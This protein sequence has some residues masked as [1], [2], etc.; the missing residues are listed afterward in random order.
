[1]RVSCLVRVDE[2][3]AA[4][5]FASVDE[6]RVAICGVRVEVSRDHAKL[7]GT[8][9][10]RLAVIRCKDHSP[11]ETD[12]AFTVPTRLIDRLV[13]SIGERDPDSDCWDEPRRDGAVC[14]AHDDER[15][16]VTLT[17]DGLFSI[18]CPSVQQH[19]FPK[20]RNVIPQGEPQPVPEFSINP[21]LLDGFQKARHRLTGNHI[22][23][24]R[25]R[26]FAGKTDGEPGPVEVRFAGVE[27]F[28]GL[29]MLMRCTDPPPPELPTWLDLEPKKEESVAA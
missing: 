11:S 16:E 28:Y 5:I 21:Y 4:R 29:L 23:G 25:L 10:R 27:K 12:G 19:P 13:V 1:M 6:S 9:S 15:N 24:V 7:I 3:E 18:S 17:V 8:D 22:D 20:W 2:L 14:L 26:H